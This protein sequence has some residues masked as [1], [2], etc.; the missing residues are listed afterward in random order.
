MSAYLHSRAPLLGI[1]LALALAVIYLA[2]QPCGECL[3]G[4]SSYVTFY[5]PSWP[6]VLSV[7]V[8]DTPEEHILGLMNREHLPEGEGMLFVFGDE[9]GRSFWMKDTL[10][11]L[12]I[13]F[14]GSSM[15]IL[16]IAEDAQP[17]VADPC[18][19]YRSSGPAMYVVEA[20][21]GFAEQHGISAGQSIGISLSQA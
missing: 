20:N 18:P 13:M 3:A 19:L 2:F 17:C 5:P 15:D 10:I 7:E 9:S 8:A 12:D 4:G 6:V 1:L 11:P 14:V 21:A 16:N